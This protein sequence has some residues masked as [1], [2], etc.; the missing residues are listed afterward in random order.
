V[1][2][3]DNPHDSEHQGQAGRHQKKGYSELEAVKELFNK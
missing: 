2:E 1:S 3:I